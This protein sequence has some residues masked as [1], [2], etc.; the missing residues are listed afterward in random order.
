M[1]LTNLLT[2][3]ALSFNTIGVYV[4]LLNA[5]VWQGPEKYNSRVRRWLFKLKGEYS[6]LLPFGLIVAGG[7]LQTAAFLLN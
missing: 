6:D 7:G 5:G 2:A 1:D 3:A 4:L